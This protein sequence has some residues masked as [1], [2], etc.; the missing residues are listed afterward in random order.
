MSFSRCAIISWNAGLPIM[1]FR[2]AWRPP[3]IVWC[4]Q[5]V[6]REGHS[7]R[8]GE[9]R[10]GGSSSRYAAETHEK[11]AG[12][13]Q[14]AKEGRVAPCWASHTALPPLPRPAGRAFPGSRA[15]QLHHAVDTRVELIAS[16]TGHGGP[17]S[18]AGANPGQGGVRRAGRAL[19]VGWDPAS[20]HMDEI[21]TSNFRT[22]RGGQAT[23]SFRF[24]AKKGPQT[25]P[26]LR[27]ASGNADATTP[28]PKLQVTRRTGSVA[29][30]GAGAAPHLGLSPVF[31]QWIRLRVSQPRLDV[32]NTVGT[33]MRHPV[34]EIVGKGLLLA[35]QGNAKFRHM[36]HSED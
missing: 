27:D 1:A 30:Q 18:G 28:D 5:D 17:Q 6:A 20:E 31:R 12:G 3:A 19:A 32:R 14:V 11:G 36:R 21:N 22:S 23:R 4:L 2:S 8:G 16:C 35:L 13:A 24:G 34:A 9:R 15:R 25:A 29:R 33:A 26:G 10:Y 7:V